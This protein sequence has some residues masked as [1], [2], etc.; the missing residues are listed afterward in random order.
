MNDR[1]LAAMLY[2]PAD[3][4]RFIQ[5]AIA[6]R[7]PTMILDLEDS[8]AA[9]RKEEARAAVGDLL[10]ATSSAPPVPW[11][12]VNPVRG[13]LCR[14]DMESVVA[15]GLGG[16]LVPKVENEED[17][18]Y[19]DRALRGL[20]AERGLTP[21]SVRIMPLI[22]SARGVVNAVAIAAAAARVLTLGFGSAD[23]LADLGLPGPGAG[24]EPSPTLVGAQVA[25]VMAC[26]V[27]G[28]RPPHD[29]AFLGLR[30]PAALES[31]CRRAR[32]IGFRGKHAIH[33][34]QVPVIRGVFR[35][36]PEE[37]AGARAILDAADPAA[38]EG[39]GAFALDGAM[40]DRAVVARAQ[41]TLA[42]GAGD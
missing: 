24:A 37:L 22:E 35:P 18:T 7:L 9:G 17:V 19:L 23:F 10:A 16:L 5:K 13:D 6:L 29:G 41:E 14:L 26:R 27:A 20:E 32:A 8:V 33:P 21:G 40:I 2:V 1:A 4:P 34:D 39:G 25:L 15:P 30:D 38:P 12:R 11:V 36:S 31:E 42:W 28:V 3:Q